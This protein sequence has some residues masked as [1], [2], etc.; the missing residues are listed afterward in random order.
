MGFNLPAPWLPGELGSR[1]R[2]NDVRG[3]RYALN[4][5][6]ARGGGHPGHLN[7]RGRRNFPLDRAAASFVAQRLASRTGMAAAMASQAIRKPMISKP[8]VSLRRRLMMISMGYHQGCSK[9]LG[10]FL[11]IH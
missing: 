4:W 3:A 5:R 8:T 1:L 7:A 10:F 11:S 2:G 9:G 6:H